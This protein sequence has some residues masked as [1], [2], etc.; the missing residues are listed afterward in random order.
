MNNQL[1]LPVITLLLAVFNLSAATL[2]VSLVSTNPM[3]PYTNWVTAATNIQQ[4]VG[5][6]AAGDVVVV[7]NGAYPGGVTAT[8]RLT[9]VSVNGPQSTVI[10]GGGGTRC[11]VLASGAS[12]SGFTLTGG[13]DTDGNGG[14]GVSGGTLYNCT[15]TGNSA[16]H[17]G[18]AIGSTLNNCTVTF[19]MAPSGWGGYWSGFGGGAFACVLSNCVLTGNSVA[20][21]GGGAAGST[22]YNCTLTGNSASWGGG[23]VN[24]WLHN[25]TVTDN[26]NVGAYSTY[27]H[28]SVL[29]DCTLSG[30][31]GEGAV[32]SMLYNCTLSGNG[33]DGADG[34]TLYNCTLRGNSGKG[35]YGCTLYNCTLTGNGSGGVYGGTNYNCILYGNTALGGANYD[36]NSTLNYCCTTPLPTN[37]VGNITLPPLFVAYP[38]NLRLQ[39]NSPC[40]NAGNNAYVTT[41]TDLDGRPRIVGGAVDMGAYE[42]QPGVSGAFIG[43]LQQYGLPTDGSADF[44]DTDGDGMNNWQEWVCGTDPTDPLSVLRLLSPS[45]TSTNA[46]VSWQSVAGVDYSL[47]RSA[48]VAS[49]FLLVA[50]NIVGQAGTTSYGDTNATG[51]GPFFYRVG[52]KSP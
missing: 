43:W 36:S 37:G 40:I 25:C 21:F 39:S 51:A 26:S 5:A 17:G 27:E 31:S 50:T 42:F 52:V 15:L 41:T 34:S 48:N 19:N 6:A 46:T 16:D 32:M 1:R 30:N 20:L 18:G 38:S 22:L 13:A 2:Y 47:E 12:L 45:V 33:Y 44:V 8:N 11:A 10:D 35:A 23:T 9:L 14:G 28:G 49:P 4:A 24:C 29:Y 3:P 7:T